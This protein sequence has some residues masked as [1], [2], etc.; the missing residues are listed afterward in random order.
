MNHRQAYTI[1]SAASLTL[2][3]ALAANAYRLAPDKPSSIQALDTLETKVDSILNYRNELL[4]TVQN[5][6]RHPLDQNPQVIPSSIYQHLRRMDEEL[7]EIGKT[8]R[9]QQ[10]AT[11]AD[12]AAHSYVQGVGAAATGYLQAGILFLIGGTFIAN[13][14]TNSRPKD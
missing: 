12:T 1:A 2:G 10:G 5:Q 9:M 4:R 8:Y 7:T 14:V 13:A 3:A 6:M 11:S